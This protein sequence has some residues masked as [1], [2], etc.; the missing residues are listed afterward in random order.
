MG[1][2]KKDSLRQRFGRILRRRR[3]FASKASW[4]ASE[5]LHILNALPSV[6]L[7]HRHRDFSIRHLS[8]SQPVLLRPN[9]CDLAA[10]AELL[11]NG[12][13]RNVLEFV[14]PPVRNVLDLG[15]NIGLSV[16]LWQEYFPDVSVLVVE[17][18]ANNL[19]QLT[20]NI[21]AG[22]SPRQV[23]IMRAFASARPGEAAISCT[24]EGMGVRMT[25][26]AGDDS[27][28]I[29]KV[30]VRD[31]V[32]RTAG[33]AGRV[34]LLKCDVEGSEAEIFADCGEWLSKVDAAVVETHPPYNAAALLA[35]VEKAWVRVA[36]RLVVEKDGGVYLVWMQFE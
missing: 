15:G 2:N 33:S 27:E 24:C 19:S 20:K 9:T 22:P 32:L 30:A 28:V 16:R 10:M 18:A 8:L 29:P 17:P 1:V 26:A 6:P 7:P 14:R 5:Y 13:Y 21:E 3:E 23:V 11:G 25:D 4:V 31:L 12:E 36:K 34:G 35:D